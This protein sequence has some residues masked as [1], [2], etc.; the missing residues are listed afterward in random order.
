MSKRYTDKEKRKARDLY[1]KRGLNLTE[2]HKKTGIGHRTLWGWKKKD[3]WDDRQ[4]EISQAVAKK[5]DEIDAQKIAQ[6]ESNLEADYYTTKANILL[7]C[8]ARSETETDPYKLKSLSDATDSAYEPL[9]QRVEE[10]KRSS[11]SDRRLHITV[12]HIEIAMPE[13]IQDMQNLLTGT[14]DDGSGG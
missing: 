13:E 3:E 10:I 5:K 6:S 9:R 12:V 14:D 11:Q 2:I 1:V 7:A 8:K 4:R